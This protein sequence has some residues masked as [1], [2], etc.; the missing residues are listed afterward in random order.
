MITIEESRRNAASIAAQ[1]ALGLHGDT[2]RW[3]HFKCVSGDTDHDAYV[4]LRS[5]AYSFG[6]MDSEWCPHCNAPN[7]RVMPELVCSDWRP[8]KG[9]R[10]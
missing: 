3:V 10:R 5:I 4:E 1:N 8:S 6:I 2:T 7:H 9:R